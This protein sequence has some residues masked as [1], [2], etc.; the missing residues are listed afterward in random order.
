MYI[1]FHSAKI[2]GDKNLCKHSPATSLVNGDCLQ[3]RGKDVYI[4]TQNKKQNMTMNTDTMHTTANTGAGRVRKV[5]TIRTSEEVKRARIQE[6]QEMM[7]AKKRALLNAVEQAVALPEPMP[8]M[9]PTEPI[10]P[11]PVMGTKVHDEQPMVS[12]NRKMS[13]MMEGIRA[14]IGVFFD[15]V[16]GFVLE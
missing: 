1:C 5:M 11:E 14:S 13:D 12:T 16:Q 7:L 6:K 8:K 10:V 9:M 15:K 3:H 4:C 2:Y